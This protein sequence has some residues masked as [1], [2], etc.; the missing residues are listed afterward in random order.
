MYGQEL[1]Q[2]KRNASW[3]REITEEF[4]ARWL[5]GLKR[6]C[7]D[8]GIVVGEVHLEG[9]DYEAC[10]SCGGQYICCDCRRD[11]DYEV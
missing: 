2:W 6:P 8:C 1:R 4:E 7:H 11:E 3:R 9:C 5:G 10:P